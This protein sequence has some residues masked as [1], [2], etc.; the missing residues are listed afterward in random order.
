MYLSSGRYVLIYLIAIILANLSVAAFGPT[1]IVV[2]AFLFIGLDL[3]ARDHLHEAWRYE[4]LA[5]KMGLLIG[6]GSV[7][8]WVLNR[9]A[10]MIAIASFM[11][12]GLAAM[13]DGITYHKLIKKPWLLKINGSNLV[14]AMVDSVTFPTIAFGI[15]MP[16]IIAGQFIAKVGGGLA[17]S[18]ILKR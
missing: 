2:N 18:L 5:Y 12:F 14:G 6:A 11:A 16:G 15:L 8:S 10:G 9:D 3:T 4:G 17:W 7:L 1:V 13:A